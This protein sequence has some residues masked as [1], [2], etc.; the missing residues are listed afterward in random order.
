MKKI[1]LAIIILLIGSNILTDDRGEYQA[2]QNKIANY[3]KLLQNN[4]G[5]VE[6]R[7]YYK[8][9]ITA[10]KIRLRDF[11]IVAIDVDQD[12]QAIDTVVK[13]ID[14]DLDSAYKKAD[15]SYKSLQ[16]YEIYLIKKEVKEYQDELDQK[17]KE[18]DEIMKKYKNNKKDTIHTRTREGF[19]QE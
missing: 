4:A 19:K 1:L 18:V 9:Q 17:M 14:I 2:I 7:N 13:P 11:N 15:E 6:Q 8:R 10:L 5:T 16:D 3:R 12:M